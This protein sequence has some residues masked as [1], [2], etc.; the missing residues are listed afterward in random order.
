MLKQLNVPT[1]VLGEGPLWHEETKEFVFADIISGILYAYDPTDASLEC[2]VLLKSK[3]QLGA[4]VF[5]E[6]GDLIVLTEGGVFHCPYGKDE[7]HFTL[8]FSIHMDASSGER[9]NDAICD[10]AGRII[11]GTK[12]EQNTEGTLWIFETG[13]EPRVLL[14]DLE[15]TN[16]MGFTKDHK[17]FYHTDSGKRTIYQYDYDLETGSISNQRV[18]VTLTSDD[19][20]VPDGMTVDQLDNIWSACWGNG[21]VNCY[22]PDGTV[23][24]SIEVSA[25][26]SSSLTFGGEAYTTLLITSAA[27]GTSGAPNGNIWI[28]SCDFV[29]KK[30]Y[31]MK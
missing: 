16:G 19:G 17:T 11:S 15:I 28:T 31:R 7:S 24:N 20:A 30:E 22:A 1:C 4:F 6:M 3:Y 27:V 13:K 5:D 14:T 10:A 8:L 21:T 23:I 2:R 29:G 18:F 26:Q 12:K 25:T 9:F